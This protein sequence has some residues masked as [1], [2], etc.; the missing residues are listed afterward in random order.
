M[1][2]RYRHIT[3]VLMLLLLSSIGKAQDMQFTQFYAAPVYLNP[4]FTGLTLEHRFASNYRKQ[5]PAIP[6]GFNNFSFSYDYNLSDINSGIGLL[7]ATEKAGSGGLKQ[8]EVGFTYAYHI[9]IK[10]HTYIQAGMSFTYVTRSIDFNK[11][12]FN[13]QL[14]RGGGTSVDNIGFNSVGYLDIGSGF[15]LYSKKYYFGFTLKHL[16]TPNQSLM[17]SESLVPVKLSIHGGYEF[18]LSTNGTK[19]VKADKINITVHYKSQ[20]KFDQLDL[21][22]YYSHAPFSFG[23]WYRGIPLLKAYRPGLA[24][25]DALALIVGYTIPERNLKFGYS[26][27]FTISRL[28]SRTAGSH[29]ISVVYEVASK[30]KKRKN[31]RFFVPCAK[32]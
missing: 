22:F 8:T 11:L 20:A 17:Q 6:G 19:K 24:N 15:L 21:G 10:R 16:N 32:F 5:W 14:Y 31:K 4:A 13:D 2:S 12:V 27:D 3:F 26:Y 29:E 7:A 1:I 23:L 25:N 30:K 18:S 28:V 9:R